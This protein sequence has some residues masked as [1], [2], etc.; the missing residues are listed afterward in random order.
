MMQTL[1]ARSL[2]P[3]RPSA[4][5]WALFVAVGLI[6][7]ALIG[8]SL[9]NDWVSLSIIAQEAIGVIFA[10]SGFTGAYVDAWRLDKLGGER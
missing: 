3:E 9:T 4:V 8:D 2:L 7:I 10:V 6:G 5:S 1:D